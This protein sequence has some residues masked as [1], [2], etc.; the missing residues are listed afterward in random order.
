MTDKD[1]TGPPPPPTE[2]AAIKPGHNTKK[3]PS[4][5]TGV[6]LMC[7]GGGAHSLRGGAR[8]QQSKFSSIAHTL[9]LNAA[10]PRQE[11]GAQLE[12]H[13]AFLAWEARNERPGTANSKHNGRFLGR[14]EPK[15]GAPNSLR[16]HPWL[17]PEP[18][19]HGTHS[20]QPS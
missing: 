16:P 1:A 15:R 3:Q 4:E 2:E 12:K 14:K 10:L 20:K 7:A 19:M 5:G 18:H 13:T 17:M 6:K 8:G 9:R 11:A